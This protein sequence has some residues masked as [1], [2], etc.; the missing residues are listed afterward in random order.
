MLLLAGI[1]ETEAMTTK[2]YPS[3]VSLDAERTL[4]GK[5]II[6]NKKKMLELRNR[7]SGRPRRGVKGDAQDGEE[8]EEEEYVP[9]TKE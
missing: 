6:R 1:D 4:S 7:R 5:R 2:Q 8:V 9:P 3:S